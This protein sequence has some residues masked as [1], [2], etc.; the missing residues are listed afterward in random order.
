MITFI[1]DAYRDLE[2]N[3]MIF[4]TFYIYPFL[5]NPQKQEEF[6]IAGTYLE[7]RNEYVRTVWMDKQIS[8]VRFY[9]LEFVQIKLIKIRIIIDTT[10]NCLPVRN[11]SLREI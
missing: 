3:K 5:Q 10:L 7:R 2:L 4:H 9:T 1:S 6:E 8:C 11:T